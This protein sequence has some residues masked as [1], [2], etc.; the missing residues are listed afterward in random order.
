MVKAG[1]MQICPGRPTSYES[2]AH[3][4]CSTHTSPWTHHE[5]DADYAKV[6]DPADFLEKRAVRNFLDYQLSPCSTKLCLT[7]CQVI[8]VILGG[9]HEEI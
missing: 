8:N 4:P 6:Q 5:V 3:A 7:P 1:H 2:K 9:M